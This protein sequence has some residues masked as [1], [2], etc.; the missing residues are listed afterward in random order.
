MR[1]CSSPLVSVMLPVYNHVNFAEAAIRSAVEQEYPNL[2]VVVRDDGSTDGSREL[3]RDLA[4]RYPDRLRLMDENGRLGITGNC[5][6]ILTACRGKYI[7][8]HAG[9]DLWMPGKVA[10]QVAWLEADER[11][12][13]CGH[14]V[15]VF[16]S[17]SGRTLYHFADRFPLRSGVGA[18]EWVRRGVL[19]GGVAM[20]V[21]AAAMP[22]HHYDPR[23]PIA[24]DWLL[25]IETLAHGGH[26]G[27]VD[28]VLSRYR[29]HATNISRTL[30]DGARDDLFVT[31]ALVESRYPHLVGSSRYARA[32]VY[33]LAG[34]HAM[35][36]GKKATARTYW[37]HSLLE[38]PEW[39][40]P[41]AL[42]LSLL[43]NRMAT[44]ILDKVRPDLPA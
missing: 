13:L 32:G 2:E 28:G 16:E 39:R 30:S 8:F 18:G 44:R 21:R 24:S 15:D 38:H 34:V 17:D 36:A 37:M 43:P 22:P 14:D 10:R 4:L 20:M 27:Y 25:W 40:A 42:A 35:R 23:V 29:R 5:N 33:R 9:D 1:A 26:F 7:G 3:L 31:L 41:S 12:V 6:R 19:F 11:R